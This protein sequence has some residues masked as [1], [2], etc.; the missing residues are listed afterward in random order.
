MCGV[1]VKIEN[2]PVGT[3]KRPRLEHGIALLASGRPPLLGSLSC[4]V[5]SGVDRHVRLSSG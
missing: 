2:V 3:F 1:F 4:S 5:L